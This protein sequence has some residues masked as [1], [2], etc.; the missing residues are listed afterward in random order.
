MRKIIKY[1]FPLVISASYS[2]TLLIILI[3]PQTLTSAQ[4][5]DMV[6]VKGGSFTRGYS[7]D[8]IKGT[9]E[10]GMFRDVPPH[11]VVLN[12]FYISKYEVTQKEFENIMGYN[13]SKFKGE[14][15]PVESVSW[16]EAVKYCNLLSEKNGL[17]T[18]YSITNE[19]VECDFSANGYRLLTEAEWEYAARGGHL[20]KNNYNYSGSDNADE[21]GWIR[22][23]S[24]GET[25]EVGLKK[26]NDLEIYDMSGNVSEWCW[27]WYFEYNSETKINPKGPGSGTHRLERGGSWKYK[28]EASGIT[29]RHFVQPNESY[30]RLGFRIGRS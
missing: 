4:V 24:N 20:S 2:I 18:C 1:L 12:D 7:K 8:Y 9:R 19:N 16:Y 13:S 22:S 14:K 28:K 29:R 21:V 5:K 11:Q 15:K 17:T 30:Q 27:D 6:K 25:H 10:G 26:P 23:N 3:F